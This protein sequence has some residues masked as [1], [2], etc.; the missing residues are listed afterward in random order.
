MYV[1]CVESS[2]SIRGG[3][4]ER[5][6]SLLSAPGSTK[7]RTDATYR[8]VGRMVGISA[9]WSVFTRRIKRRMD[10]DLFDTIRSPTYNPI[11]L[12]RALNG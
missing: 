8:M 11:L 4:L 3:S 1:E 7:K 6:E 5:N 9:G 2:G 10:P 12:R